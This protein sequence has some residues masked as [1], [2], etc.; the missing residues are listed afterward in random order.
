M[1]TQRLVILVKGQLIFKGNHYKKPHRG[2]DELAESLFS[3][4]MYEN[5]SMELAPQLWE[6]CVRHES[7]SLE[8]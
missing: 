7:M 3:L 5:T 2:I 4:K 1:L 6:C 8:K